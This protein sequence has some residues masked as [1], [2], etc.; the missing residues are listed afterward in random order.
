M[1][2]WPPHVPRF[3]IQQLLAIIPTLPCELILPRVA[4]RD[5]LQIAR[6]PSCSAKWRNF[7]LAKALVIMSARFSSVG[8]Y[9]TKLLVFNC[10]TYEM[11]AAINMFGPQMVFVVFRQHNCPLVIAV[12]GDSTL[13]LISQLSEKCAQPQS[14]LHCMCL[15]NILSFYCQKCDYLLFLG[16][17]AHWASSK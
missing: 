14:L 2:T 13:W 17:P 1:R 15:S 11:V 8:M 5:L 6:S 7:S 12:N 4:S 10:L 9:W 16:A 3:A